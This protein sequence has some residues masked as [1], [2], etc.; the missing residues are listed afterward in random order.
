MY[1]QH[2]RLI[3]IQ[4][5]LVEKTLL[6]AGD[7]KLMD[8]RRVK[9]LKVH[10]TFLELHSETALQHSLLVTEDET[11]NGFVRLVR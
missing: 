3:V 2:P 10:K 9:F 6:L 1:I 7:Q 11:Q 4:L 8:G 5:Y